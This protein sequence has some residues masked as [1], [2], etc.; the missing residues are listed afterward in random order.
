MPNRTFAELQQA[1]AT[2]MQL[3]PGLISDEERKRFINDCLADLGD[4]GLFEKEAVLTVTNGEAALPSDFVS[5]ISVR[6]QDG[7]TLR[8]AS[9]EEQIVGSGSKPVKFLLMP[10]KIRVIP[11]ADGEL[12]LYY[13]YRPAPLEA[14]TDVPDIPEGYDMLIVDYSVARAHRKNGNIG[15]WREYMSYYE[16]GKLRLANELLRRINSRVTPMH[17]QHHEIMF[18]PLDSF[19]WP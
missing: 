9:L 16:S 15:L 14:D 8:P 11:A 6:W 10:Q 13:G 1:I 5:L 3:D 2:E 19:M 18:D 7:R 4:M 12:M 17:N